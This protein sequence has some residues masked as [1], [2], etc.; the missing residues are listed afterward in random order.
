VGKLANIVLDTGEI[1]KSAEGLFKALVSGEPVPVE[2]K[3]LPVLTMR[4]AAKHIFVTNVLPRF[5]DTSNGMWR[6][7]EIILF[8][9]I[10]PIEQRDPSLKFRLL[11]EMPAIIAWALR[12]LA[13]LLR[14]GHFTAVERSREVL[15]N[16]REESNPVGLYLAAECL[17]D[18]DGRISRKSV[19]QSYKRWAND[20]GHCPLSSTKFYR[21]VGVILP[22][23]AEQPR[24]G[25]GGDRM[26][27]GLRLRH[28]TDVFSRLQ[29][30]SPD[31]AEAS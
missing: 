4:L 10:C 26:F 29:I 3:H 31:A 2:E 5:H 24:D 22:Q 16:Y 18:V 11:A 27:V 8:D 23:P 1:E 30:L 25:R 6:R 21:E 19:Y 12:G 15:R 28:E 7:L 17:R 14:Q 13:R 9:R 20:N